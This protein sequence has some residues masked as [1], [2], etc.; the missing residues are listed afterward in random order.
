MMILTWII[1][2]SVS[3][4]FLHSKVTFMFHFPCYNL[5]WHIFSFELF[6]TF[7]HYSL[8]QPWSQTFSTMPWLTF[9]WRLVSETKIWALATDSFSRLHNWSYEKLRDFLKVQR[10]L[11]A[12]LTLEHQYLDAWV[13]NLAID[14]TLPVLSH[15]RTCSL[16]GDINEKLWPC[17]LQSRLSKCPAVTCI[18]I[19]VG[20]WILP[21]KRKWKQGK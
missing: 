1:I 16:H 6:L 5:L 20:L 10:W 13:T 7:Q 4:R 18:F 17:F 19:Y 15:S 2:S 9:Y 21:W 12:K 3:A 14:T 11:V 8:P